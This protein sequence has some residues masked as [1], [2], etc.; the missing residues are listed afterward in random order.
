MHAHT[1]CAGVHSHPTLSQ[2]GSTS[3]GQ[4]NSRSSTDTS[5]STMTQNSS[6]LTEPQHT[7][8]ADKRPSQQHGGIDSQSPT[9]YSKYMFGVDRASHDEDPCPSSQRPLAQA[10]GG[11]G[12]IPLALSVTMLS[13][14]Y[15]SF[16]QKASVL[17]PP[18]SSTASQRNSFPPLRAS[19]GGPVTVPTGEVEPSEQSFESSSVITTSESA[20]DTT[21]SPP[22]LQSVKPPHLTKAASIS[23][24][25]AQ[26]PRTAQLS[27]SDMTGSDAQELTS[28]TSKST[29]SAGGDVS[30]G[31]SS[32]TG[33]SGDGVGSDGGAGTGLGGSL[34]PPIKGILKHPAERRTH[35]SSAAASSAPSRR[36]KGKAVSMT[37]K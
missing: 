17:K 14:D 28:T 33:S 3:G 27:V 5:H 31:S 9:K 13:S 21:G 37:T 34:R 11:K 25:S 30:S 4:D 29:S 16:Q 7:T 2:I 26:P 12:D 1:L 15:S 23:T 8:S 18:P 32:T 36:S 22:F 10:Q 35:S 19:P 24:A 6:S 20:Q